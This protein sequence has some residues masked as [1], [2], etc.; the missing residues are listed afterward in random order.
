MA[1]TRS[2]RGSG[3]RRQ[4]QNEAPCSR[5]KDADYGVLGAASSASGFDAAEA[6]A[7][8]AASQPVVIPHVPSGPWA[9]PI[10]S[11]DFVSLVAVPDRESVQQRS[12]HGGALSAALRRCSSGHTLGHVQGAGSV[13]GMQ[14]S[15][16]AA[17]LGSGGLGGAECGEV[18][19]GLGGHA[20]GDAVQGGAHARSVT[21][22]RSAV[23]LHAKNV[24]AA[25]THAVQPQQDTSCG[26]A[27]TGQQAGAAMHAALAQAMQVSD[28]QTTAAPVESPAS[29]TDASGAASDT[30]GVLSVDSPHQP[31]AALPSS[32]GSSG[33]SWS[34]RA[35]RA[36]WAAAKMA[37]QARDMHFSPDHACMPAVMAAA[38]QLGTDSRLVSEQ[39]RGS[40]PAALPDTA[41]VEPL[42]TQQPA[43]NCQAASSSSVRRPGDQ[44]C[45]PVAQG[46][47]WAGAGSGSPPMQAEGPPALEAEGSTES[48]ATAPT[49]TTA[50]GQTC[51][52]LQ[53][54]PVAG[55]DDKASSQLVRTRSVQ[56]HA[57]TE[58]HAISRFA[59]VI[60]RSKSLVAPLPDIAPGS[61]WLLA[62]PPPEGVGDNFCVADTLLAP[63][64][65]PSTAAPES[66]VSGLQ[67]LMAGLAVDV[68]AGEDMC[69]ATSAMERITGW[70]LQGDEAGAAAGQ[71]TADAG[72]QGAGLLGGLTGLAGLRGD[73][74]NSSHDDNSF[75]GS[76]VASS[77]AESVAG[78]G[79]FTPLP[80]LPVHVGGAQL[81]DVRMGPCADQV[82]VEQQAAL[83]V[84]TAAKSGLLQPIMD[85]QAG[86]DDVQ[87]WQAAA[88]EPLA[89]GLTPQRSWERPRESPPP[90][91]LPSALGSSRAEGAG[92][93]ACRHFCATSPAACGA[94]PSAPPPT[95]SPSGAAAHVV[96]GQ[97]VAP[98]LR[99]A[100]QALAPA[101]ADSPAKDGS[102]C[103]VAGLLRA[104]AAAGHAAAV[105]NPSPA[106]TGELLTVA[107]T[108]YAASPAGA[109]HKLGDGQL[110]T[111]CPP[112]MSD[113]PCTPLS[114]WTPELT[115]FG[116]MA[117]TPPLVGHL[118]SRLITAPTTPP[119][120]PPPSPST[121]LQLHTSASNRHQLDIMGAVHALGADQDAG[122]ALSTTCST[123]VPSPPHVSVQ[124]CGS[125]GAA[126]SVGSIQPAVLARMGTPGSCT[127]P[128]LPHPA[129]HLS[130][131]S[132]Q[133]YSSSTDRC[134]SRTADVD[135]VPLS[136]SHFLE[137]VYAPTDRWA[138]P[139]VL[140]RGALAR[141]PAG[142]PQPQSS[143]SSS[144]SSSGDSAAS[145][146][147]AYGML[148][149]SARAN[150]DWRTSWWGVTGGLGWQG[151]S[152][153]LTSNF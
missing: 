13:G 102:A 108:A 37:A 71:P 54:P 86:A 42:T 123:L 94:R 7:A 91:P 120:A 85:G 126:S 64:A 68:P 8:A 101:A 30:Q 83:A 81:D 39:L 88:A 99:A 31:A 21:L 129:A 58:H 89:A 41:P 84:G 80:P 131:T 26:V 35:Y 5:E 9:S 132:Q 3:S 113:A 33:T 93:S 47:D 72:Q 116:C 62:P 10:M 97:L 27:G 77:T 28:Y 53:L 143:G 57:H 32:G 44:C 6:A 49:A 2:S 87:V 115:A 48:T 1:H 95:A 38:A 119:G 125:V 128:P 92:T 22:H 106:T 43:S 69:T 90:Y 15:A 79:R 23:P 76:S 152:M 56:S 82:P 114:R 135:P 34:P 151:D 40:F 14:R 63:A 12:L 50:Q 18:H 36:A 150:D 117:S 67:G 138:P 66:S 45:G 140:P 4:S 122:R 59:P 112:V 75:G 20:W 100:A 137:C 98:A 149:R 61:M 19:M 142:N 145:N 74:G 25:A 147:P 11:Q 55:T 111:S 103:E 104:A 121:S 118:P 52:H 130:R 29:G 153:P 144:G 51:Q 46:D 127:P 139:S 136:P 73:L 133:Q 107:N 109:E 60:G 148:A 65:A 146:G 110:R 78:A 96:Q 124:A 105:F 134:S 16:S 141:R 24:N 17:W 70:C